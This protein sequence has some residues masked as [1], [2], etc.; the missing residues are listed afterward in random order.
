V[1][2]RPVFVG[3]IESLITDHGFSSCAEPESSESDPPMWNLG[4][5]SHYSVMPLV[6]LV[7][8]I[9]ETPEAK[10][11]LEEFGIGWLD[12]DMDEEGD[13]GYSDDEEVE[14]L[15]EDEEEERVD[16]LRDS[17]RLFG[18]IVKLVLQQIDGRG[19]DLSGFIAAMSE[20]KPDVESLVKQV[21]ENAKF[22][23]ESVKQIEEALGNVEELDFGGDKEE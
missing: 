16:E 3:L 4:I 2:L 11:K 14:F 15:D 5:F 18:G 7:A 23:R 1:N 6:L 12:E 20:G 19:E 9:D 21:R 13:L 17:I 10:L 8:W 22:F